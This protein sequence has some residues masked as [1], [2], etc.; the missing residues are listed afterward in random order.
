[1]GAEQEKLTGLVAAPYTPLHEDGQLNC[2]RIPDLAAFLARNGVS[3]AFV[4]GTTGEGM[5]LSIEEREAVTE[6][7]VNASPPDLRIVV[8]VGHA[9]LPDCRRLAA[10]AA[11]KGAWGIGQMAPCF[12]KPASL[13][14]LVD[15]CAQT[16]AC[17][18]TLP[19]YYYHMP[20]MTGVD[21]KMV[22]FLTAAKDRIPNLA[23]V[24]FTHEDLMD[25]QLCRALDG[26]RFD[27]LFGRDELLVCGL[28][29]GCTGAVGSTYNFLAP[30]Y[31]DIWDAFARG[32]LKRANALQRISMQAVRV[33]FK[34]GNPIVC[35]KAIMGLLGIE[36]G[37]VRLP[38][39]SPSPTTIG[40]LVEELRTV[41]FHDHCSDTAAREW[42]GVPCGAPRVLD[43]APAMTVGHRVG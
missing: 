38:L 28:A 14:D 36:C 35:G 41:G 37:P 18:P 4:C 2:D 1:M 33:M 31:L 23:G 10:H 25:M 3:G 5:S 17:A 34:H 15:F 6:S 24:K 43:A 26:G 7:W 32:D 21:V 40:Q 30:L 20:A 13:D 16:A 12:F 9:S 29:L 39:R 22:D 8:H 27:M 11:A 19:Y 42:K